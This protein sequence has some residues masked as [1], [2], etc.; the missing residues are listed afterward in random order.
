[1]TDTDTKA[2]LR[3]IGFLLVPNFSLIAFSSAF[4]ALRM[5][6]RMR[7]QTIYEWQVLTFDGEPIK[8]SSNLTVTPDGDIASADRLEIELTNG[9]GC[10]SSSAD[11][12]VTLERLAATDCDLV[13]LE[14]SGVA[15][16]LAL[17]QI[18]E[19]APGLDLDCIVTVVDATALDHH[20]ARP[21]LH[22]L[23]QRQLDAAHVVV[24]SHVDRVDDDRLPAVMQRLADLVPGRPIVTSTLQDASEWTKTHEHT[25]LDSD[26]VEL[27]KASLAGKTGHVMYFGS[28]NKV[29]M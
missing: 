23:V 24:L 10:C 7:E 26:T 2:R 12:A 22:A 5:A 16:P 6:N 18:V 20:L 27:D 3:R 15:D 13:V 14:A 8:S 17:A 25:M 21:T 29:K 9:C 28:F 19:V 4:D 11:L 1:M